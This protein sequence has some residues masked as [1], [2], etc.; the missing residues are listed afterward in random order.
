MSAIITISKSELKNK[1]ELLKTIQTMSAEL[2]EG[3]D[4]YTFSPKAGYLYELLNCFKD[5]GINYRADFGESEH[6]G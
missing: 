6:D 3:V 1:P 5:N 2:S 4:G